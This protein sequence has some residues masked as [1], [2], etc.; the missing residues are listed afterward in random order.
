MKRAIKKHWFE[1]SISL[2]VLALCILGISILFGYM[3]RTN[4][5]VLLRSLVSGNY[6][7]TPETQLFNM[8]YPMALIYKGLYTLNGDISWYDCIIVGLH[9]L[10][11]FLIVF[12]ITVVFEKKY[13]KL[14]AIGLGYCGLV[15]LDLQY[16]VMNQYTVLAAVCVS[17]A[18]LW[19][20]LVNPRNKEILGCQMMV[21]VV[22]M[23]V[24]LW[25]REEVFLMAIP[26]GGCILVYQW[27]THYK[28]SDFKNVWL[29]M[30]LRLLALITIISAVSF[31]VNSLAL[32]SPEWKYFL[33]YNNA[34]TEIFDYYYLAPYDL[35]AE[36]YEEEGIS[37]AGY[38]VV[39]SMSLALMPELDAE[40]LEKLANLSKWNKAQMEQYYSVYRKTLY[41]VMDV[42]FHN[43]VQP[44][45]FVLSISAVLLLAVSIRQKDKG[46]FLS[47]ILVMSYLAVFTGYF[48]WKNRFP[49]RVSYGLY[50]MIFAFFLGILLQE[51][52]AHIER[53]IDKKDWFWTVVPIG[54][55]TF[56]LVNVGLYQYRNIRDDIKAHKIGIEQW[57]QIQSYA[58]DN[59]ENIYFVK[60]NLSG[61][62]GDLLNLKT[63]DEPSN[64]LLLGTWL[65]E[66]PHYRMRS[67]KL[68]LDDIFTDFV[69]EDNIYLLQ[70]KD[71]NVEWLNSYYEEYGYSK[72]A[73]IVDVI[74]TVDGEINV[75]QMR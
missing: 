73:C 71:E 65:S 50:S 42:V 3:H 47:E 46:I 72:K 52:K 7:G 51:L 25:M 29:R 4:D 62:K 13:H 10:C 75:I 32:S 56:V 34:R 16:V 57:R 54:I 21:I 40:K 39:N 9:Y 2:A 64:I 23:T 24:A 38:E 22:L 1:L 49:D 53:R 17:T 58:E 61:L 41:S 8:M 6:T 20:V 11:W 60:A 19:L 70:L 48:L 26:I 36:I 30:Q 43:E 45:A 5:D 14:L 18:I 33:R 12:R 27:I 35:Y 59:N 15:L 55:L 44:M 69:V 67:E 63:K 28:D 31:S 37:I 66:S 74:E 68:G